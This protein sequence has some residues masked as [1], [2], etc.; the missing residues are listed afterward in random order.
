[1]TEAT[2]ANN[3]NNEVI[4]PVANGV[5]AT[6]GVKIPGGPDP[7]GPPTNPKTDPKMGVRV[8]KGVCPNTESVSKQPVETL[9]AVKSSPAVETVGA[10]VT[11]GA[12]ETEVGVRVAAALVV[13]TEEVVQMG[14]NVLLVIEILVNGL[15]ARILSHSNSAVIITDTTIMVSNL[16]LNTFR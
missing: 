14:K 4:N 1:M 2:E 8:K 13:V 7:T 11:A 15:I 9:Q 12:V 16:F 3:S 10:G 6:P 5:M